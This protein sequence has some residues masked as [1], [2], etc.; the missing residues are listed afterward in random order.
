MGRGVARVAIGT[1]FVAS[2]ACADQ[3]SE[4]LDVTS[5]ALLESSDECLNAVRDKGTKYEA[6]PACNALS[7]LSMKYIEAGGATS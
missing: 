1:V 6:T 5:Q 4:R 2:L 3:K 7:S